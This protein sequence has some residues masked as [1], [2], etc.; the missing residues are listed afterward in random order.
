MTRRGLE[1]VLCWY[2]VVLLALYLPLETWASLPAGLLSPYYIVDLVG[3]ALL[4]LGVAA[5]FNAR[6]YSNPAILCA[7][8]AWCAANGWRA[9]ADRLSLINRGEPLPL[10]GI[11]LAVVG[12]STLAAIFV[13]AALAWQLWDGNTER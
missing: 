6:P 7:G 3:M 4:A 5:S 1:T 10:G 12:G 8:Y 13:T 9:T 2:T 11:E